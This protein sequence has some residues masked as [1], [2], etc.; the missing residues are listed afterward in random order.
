MRAF[1]PPR[2]TS[3]SLLRRHP[4][5]SFEF[6]TLL[7]AHESLERASGSRLHPIEL[8]RMAVLHFQVGQFREG[9]VRFR[10]LREIQRRSDVTLP[11]VRE[12]WRQFDKPTLP[13][14][15]R[16][17]VSRMTNE[18]RAEGYSDQLNLTIPLRPRH[19]SPLSPER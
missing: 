16:I 14:L 8:F 18:W 9:D 3:L 11:A 17:R 19:F 10:T 1:R 4:S 7:E 2:R 15:T 5:R 13:R 12:I 6:R